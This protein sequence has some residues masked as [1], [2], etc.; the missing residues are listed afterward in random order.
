MSKTK[1]MQ[2][3]WLVMGALFVAF[4]MCFVTDTLVITAIS[5]A[6]TGVIGA[7][8]GVDLVAMIHKTKELPEG[9]Y[10]RM[11]RHRYIIAL[12]IFASLLLESFA[13]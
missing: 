1:K 8:L 5:T 11:N 2:I 12:I 3:A 13:I 10:K 4:M 6:F 7:F 9:R